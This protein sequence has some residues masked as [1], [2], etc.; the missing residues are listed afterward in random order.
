MIT[1]T[2][3]APEQ[4]RA[5]LERRRSGAA[6]KHADRRT[7]RNRER[8]SSRSGV[9]PSTRPERDGDVRHPRADL[10]AGI[11]SRRGE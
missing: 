7:R 10:F 5:R 9:T 3:A 1:E 6:G 11:A 2:A 8:R 4:L